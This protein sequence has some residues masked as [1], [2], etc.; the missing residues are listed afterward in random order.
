MHTKFFKIT[1]VWIK[2]KYAGY[3]ICTSPTVIWYVWDEQLDEMYEFNS[4]SYMQ[5]C[6]SSR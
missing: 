1:Q 5:M 2:K 6:I 4:N 3:M